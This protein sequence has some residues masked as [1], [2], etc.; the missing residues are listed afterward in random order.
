MICVYSHASGGNGR[1]FVQDVSDTAGV[2]ALLNAGWH[3][4]FLASP[5]VSG[6]VSISGTPSVTI[7]GPSPLPVHD[8]G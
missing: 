7:A 1:Q 6:S 2:Q 8:A 5:S 4:D 3:I